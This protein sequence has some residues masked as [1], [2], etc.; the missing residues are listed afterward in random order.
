MT[1][2]SSLNDWLIYIVTIKDV[3]ASIYTDPV[4]TQNSTLHLKSD[5]AGKTNVLP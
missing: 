1:I 3:L 2:S 4:A 5:S